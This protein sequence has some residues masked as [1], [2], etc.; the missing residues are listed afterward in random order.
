MFCF[1]SNHACAIMITYENIQATSPS[2]FSTTTVSWLISGSYYGQW[3][4]VKALSSLAAEITFP[5]S[6]GY[7]LQIWN[8]FKTATNRVE[9]NKETKRVPLRMHVEKMKINAE[10]R[11]VLERPCQRRIRIENQEWWRWDLISD[12]VLPKYLLITHLWL[13]NLIL[14]KVI[15]LAK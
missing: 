14:N 11:K 5:S 6:W 7:L 12:R 15:F 10:A 4:F 13:I 8:A 9:I 2:L 1:Q 3:V